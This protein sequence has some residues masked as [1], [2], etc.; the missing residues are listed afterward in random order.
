MKYNFLNIFLDPREL[1]EQAKSDICPFLLLNNASKIEKIYEFYKSNSSILYVS[2][3]MGTGKAKVVDYSLSFLAAETIVL[4]YNCFNSTV[5]DDILLSFFQEFKELSSQ[6]IISEPKIKTENFTQKI[7]SYFSQIEKPFVIVLDSFEALLDEN[8]PEILDFL[9]HLNSFDKIKSIIIGR[10]FESKYFEGVSTDRLTVQAL[11]REH[12][13]KYI[14][15]ERIK[16][17]TQILDEFYKNSRGYYFFVTLSLKLIKNANL[18]LV[19]FLTNF[20]KSYMP[21]FDYLGKQSLTFIPATERNLFW[22]LSL[23]RHPVSVVLLKKLN[24]Y[25]EEKINYLIDNSVLINDGINLYVQDYLKD[26][27]DEAISPHIA[28]KIRQYIIDLY[29]TQL[30]LKPL[31]RD[32]CISRQTMRKEIEYHNRFLPQR[33]K[34]IDN[35]SVDINYL[36]Y[37]KVTDFE[38]RAGKD[39]KADSKISKQ[40]E[41]KIDLTQRKNISINLENLPYQNHTASNVELEDKL[42]EKITL[43]ELMNSIRQAEF[44]YNYSKVIELCQKAFLQ[45]DDSDYE[46][47]LPSLYMKIAYAHRKLAQYDDALKY[48]NLAKNI[49]EKSNDFS[50]VNCIKFNIAKIYYEIYKI[51]IAKNLFLELT[52][53]SDSALVVKSY[54]RLANLEESLSNIDAAFDYYK[55]AIKFSNEDVDGQV[56][57]EIYFKYALA[58]D[59]KNDVKGAIQ[60]YNKCINLELESKDNKFISSAYSNLANLYLEK[61]ELKSA[62]LNFKNAYDIDKAANNIEGLYYTASKLADALSRKFPDEALYYYE[63]ALD[64]AKLLKDPF[65]TVSAA[66]SLGD[67]NYDN[68]QNEIALKNYLY[69]FNLAKDTLSQDNLNKINVR[70]N[71]IKFR[72]GVGKFDE[73]VDRIRIQNDN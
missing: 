11:E 14:K 43:K 51:D 31:E 5:L 47:F 67:F 56:L 25:D 49:Y 23:I 70:I 73:L 7:N 33:P 36:S 45:N 8:R 60:Y 24:F 10:T 61:N 17:S 62:V 71:D 32:I 39:E 59:D 64:C 1:F 54:L 42:S 69:A 16:A 37:A 58:L 12:F 28:Q 53:C 57:S 30:P 50:K 15:S 22:F 40:T 68:K 66:L 4:K 18:S 3:F 13:D 55:E 29:S 52:R 41:P 44:K 63:D 19:D 21:F 38:K 35:V 65:Y 6:K 46:P 20:E 34:N 27:A 72:L 26:F 48:F 2:G 9:F